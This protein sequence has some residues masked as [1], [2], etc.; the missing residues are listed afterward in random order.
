MRQD[1]AG[2]N[3]E[4]EQRLHSTDWKLLVKM[5]YTAAD[6]IQKNSLVEM[7]F[8]YLSAKARVAMHAA[9]V[10][11]ERR[12]EFFPEVIMTMTKLGC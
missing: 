7:K 8:T 2:E 9:G 1:N 11:K 3:K 4:L 5:E 12:L 6:T 10:P